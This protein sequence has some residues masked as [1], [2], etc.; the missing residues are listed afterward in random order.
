MSGGVWADFIPH[1]GQVTVIALPLRLLTADNLT[2]AYP[3]GVWQQPLTWEN[4][5]KPHYVLL[6]ALTFRL[7]DMWLN[8]YL[9]SVW[10]AGKVVKRCY[11]GSTFNLVKYC[12][13]WV[14]WLQFG[15]NSSSCS[16]GLAIL[17]IMLLSRGTQEL[18][19]GLSKS[20]QRWRQSHISTTNLALWYTQTF[21]SST[22][23]VWYGFNGTQCHQAFET[24]KNINKELVWI[25]AVTL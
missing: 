25:I 2:P 6:A 22:W 5:H 8:L 15:L 9:N 21:S 3:P 18:Q 19:W 13:C 23:L 10:S 16:I 1:L 4:R 14:H 20:V 24:K 12:T 7:L 17:F 11:A